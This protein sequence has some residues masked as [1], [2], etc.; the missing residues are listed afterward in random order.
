MTIQEFNKLSYKDQ[1]AII[2]AKGAPLPTFTDDHFILDL[3]ALEDFFVQHK[4]IRGESFA[5]FHAL[6]TEED[7]R[8]FKEFLD[9]YT[10]AQ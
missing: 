6:E 3:W 5:E 10:S 4:S 2:T 8:P 7:F 9:N 1:D